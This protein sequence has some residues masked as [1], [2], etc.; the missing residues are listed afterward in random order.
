MSRS[1]NISLDTLGNTKNE[2]QKNM[3]ELV[4]RGVSMSGVSMSGGMDQANEDDF[5]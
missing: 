5:E 1:I 3:N 4:D 2:R